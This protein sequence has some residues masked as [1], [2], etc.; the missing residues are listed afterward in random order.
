MSLDYYNAPSGFKIYDPDGN[1]IT[2]K[3]LLYEIN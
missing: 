1:A 2:E 3:N